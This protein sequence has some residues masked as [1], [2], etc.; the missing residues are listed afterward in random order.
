M[1]PDGRFG[2]SGAKE[3]FVLARGA[4]GLCRGWWGIRGRG[5][6]IGT[7]KVRDGNVTRWMSWIAWILVP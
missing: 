1:G 5:S 6:K 2:G 4:L 3:A 7:F